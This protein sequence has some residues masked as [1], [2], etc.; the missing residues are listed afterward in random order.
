MLTI[1]PFILGIITYTL[2]EYVVHRWL[3]HGPMVAQHREHHR[4]PAKNV[5]TPFMVVA[6]VLVVVALF[7]G[8]ALAA[9]I[10][11]GWY[12]SGVPHRKLHTTK[13]RWVWM[14]KLQK[15]H[16]VHHRQAS[17]NYGVTSVIWDKLFGTRGLP[18]D[19]NR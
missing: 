6:P 12:A 5:Q 16:M 1:L 9:G 14:V 2:I 15:H 13:A 11:V 3:L 18:P 19:E 8:V 7:V 4:N 17:K 10:M